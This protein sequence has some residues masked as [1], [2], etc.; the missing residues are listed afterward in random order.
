MRPLKIACFS[1]LFFTGQFASAQLLSEFE[2]ASENFYYRIK[3]IEFFID[4]FN[5]VAEGSGLAPEVNKADTVVYLAWLKERNTLIFTLFDKQRIRKERDAYVS[6]ENYSEFLKSVNDPYDQQYINFADSNWYATFS[7]LAEYKGK[8]AIIDCSL[9]VNR[10]GKGV[11]TWVMSSVYS[12]ELKIDEKLGDQ[13]TFIPSVH[14][15]DFM[16]VRLSLSDPSWIKAVQE[17][18]TAKSRFIELM[19]SKE[20]HLQQINNITY[21]FM[22]L[23]RWIIAVNYT[24][25]EDANSGWLVSQLL[26]ADAAAKRAYRTRL[27][28]N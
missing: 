8:P 4:R 9:K 27:H 23:D 13:L 6:R 19:F 18:S 10:S 11:Y 25:R 16:G 22:Q 7:F 21:H 26:P 3:N 20:L 24:A 17:N 5:H 1:I 28:V 12:K 14:G 2:V 15:T